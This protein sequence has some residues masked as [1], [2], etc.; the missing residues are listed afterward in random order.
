MIKDPANDL[1]EG[2]RLKIFIKSFR[3]LK[4]LAKFFARIFTHSIS[5]TRV[6]CQGLYNYIV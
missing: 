2:P 1:C 3:I 4:D 5:C 6:F